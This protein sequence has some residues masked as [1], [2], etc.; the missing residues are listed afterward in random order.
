MTTTY[1]IST[2]ADAPNA[3]QPCTAEEIDDLH[4]LNF[5]EADD[6][7]DGVA[8]AHLADGRLVYREEQ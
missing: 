7:P 3:V 8:F 5:Q 1:T 2:S 4:D 6:L